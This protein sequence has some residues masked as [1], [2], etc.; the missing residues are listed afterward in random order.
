MR[1]ADL[2][3]ADRVAR[4]ERLATTGSKAEHARDVAEFDARTAILRAAMPNDDHPDA[5]RS[6]SIGRAMLRDYPGGAAWLAGVML[7]DWHA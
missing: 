7:E 2:R 3:L 6:W 1:F 5:D 4:L